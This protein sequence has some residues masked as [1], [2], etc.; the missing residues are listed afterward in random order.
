MIKKETKFNKNN[1]INEKK[2]ILNHSTDTISETN[3][4]ICSNNEKNIKG[5]GNWY[6][7]CLSYYYY[8]NEQD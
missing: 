3:D 4:F 6:Y 8:Q 1:R 5:D 7:K 2:T